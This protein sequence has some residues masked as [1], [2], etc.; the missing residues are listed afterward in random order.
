MT[1]PR[2]LDNSGLALYRKTQG[3]ND[4]CQSRAGGASF[5]L[6][7]SACKTNTAYIFGA[8]LARMRRTRHGTQKGSHHSELGDAGG[9]RRDLAQQCCLPTLP[10]QREALRAQCLR[11]PLWSYGVAGARDPPPSA[12]LSD[13]G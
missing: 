5:A 3:P 9:R 7:L 13:R 10:R 4:C 12:A 1:G 11:T 2:A 8:T 6:V